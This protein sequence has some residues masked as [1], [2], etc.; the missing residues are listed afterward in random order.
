MNTTINTRN[1]RPVITFDARPTIPVHAWGQEV[2]G[3]VSYMFHMICP[4]TWAVAVGDHTIGVVMHDLYRRR[5]L[6]FFN[7]GERPS[8]ETFMEA[9]DVLRQS[10]AV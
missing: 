1:A 8:T 4:N 2:I 9:V 3:G 7:G 5:W 6:P 10:W